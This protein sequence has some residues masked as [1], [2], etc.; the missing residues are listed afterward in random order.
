LYIA[1]RLHKINVEK[2]DVGKKTKASL[3][4]I[5]WLNL[6][7]NFQIPASHLQNISLSLYLFKLFKERQPTYD[8]IHPL[9]ITCMKELVVVL[10]KTTPF[11]LNQIA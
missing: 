9:K 3:R 8:P 7:P 5:L 11:L 6:Q 2:S 4:S 1:L 10:L